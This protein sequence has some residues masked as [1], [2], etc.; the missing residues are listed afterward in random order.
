LALEVV[1]VSWKSI[2]AGVLRGKWIPVATLENS[3]IRYVDG[4][5]KASPAALEGASN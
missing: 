4:Q 3:E 5:G 1:A 2:D